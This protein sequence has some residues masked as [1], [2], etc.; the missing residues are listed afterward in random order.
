MNIRIQLIDETITPDFRQKIRGWVQKLETY[1]DKILE[2]KVILKKD[3]ESKD[4]GF[5]CEIRLV[6]RGNDLFGKSSA[7]N[8]AV[9][10]EKVV[11]SLRKR[12]RKKKTE[13]MAQ[14]RKG[15]SGL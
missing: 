10:T 1:H 13:K 9:A 11:E 5:F 7:E 14:R 6:I 12:L 4:K 3:N 2:A 15:R 8:F